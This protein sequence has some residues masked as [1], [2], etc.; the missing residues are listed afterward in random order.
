MKNSLP[1]DDKTHPNS[2]MCRRG[3]SKALFCQIIDFKNYG[4]LGI[5]KITKKYI[6]KNL[7][8]AKGSDEL[9]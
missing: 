3:K 9:L 7:K 8:V 1:W 4:K 6:T 2:V 5:C